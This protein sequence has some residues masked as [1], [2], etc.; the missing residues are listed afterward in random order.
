[1][2]VIGAS[3]LAALAIAPAWPLAGWLAAGTGVLAGVSLIDDFRG[4]PALLRLAVHLAV[5]A[6]SPQE[7]VA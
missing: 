4:L 3:L 6:T 1:V 2:A 5:S 7:S